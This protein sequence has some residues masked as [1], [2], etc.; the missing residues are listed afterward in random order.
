MD[1]APTP[2]TALRA[3]YLLLPA[4]VVQNWIVSQKQREIE[5]RRR[6][7]NDQERET[8]NN[9]KYSQVLMSKLA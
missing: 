6:K 3:A 8:K 1:N 9:Y 7:W 4:V 5:K 2:Y